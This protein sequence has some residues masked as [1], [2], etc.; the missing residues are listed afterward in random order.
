MYKEI[1]GKTNY[2]QAIGVLMLETGLQ[3][4]PGD[5]GN[6][7]TFPFPVAYK[8]V[9]GASPKRICVDAD[10]ELISAFVQ[11]GQ[12]LQRESGVR[13]ITTSCGFCA[14]FQKEI[15]AGLDVPF[16]SSSLIQAKLVYDFLGPNKKVGILTN[17]ANYLGEPHFKG[18]GIEHVPKV[19][20]GMDGTWLGTAFHLNKEIIE[21]DIIR[22]EIVQRAKT[23]VEENPDVGAIVLECTNMPPYA[24]DIQKAVGLPVFDIVTLT[25][26]VYSGVVAM[27]Y[28]GYL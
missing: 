14:I 3:R 16:F 10:P 28:H 23:M 11:A 5:I 9:H 8:I 25:K 20:Y 19:V 13:A 27:P 2:G 18:V 21:P 1:K 26:Y 6:A 24:A 4:I 22:R 17:E 12:E 15:Q 7:T